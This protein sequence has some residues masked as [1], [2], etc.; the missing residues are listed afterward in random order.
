MTELI[1]TRCAQE[2]QFMT[3]LLVSCR[4]GTRQYLART[5]NATEF[6]VKLEEEQVSFS[7]QVPG[8]N[9]NRA[10]LTRQGDKVQ[11]N[12]FYLPPILSL[13]V[14]SLWGSSLVEP[15]EAAMEFCRMIGCPE[16]MVG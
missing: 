16:E 6:L 10:F 14:M 13:N 9:A 7:F 4:F 1:G 5:I 12:L 11:I 15:K 2:V 3:A 8:C